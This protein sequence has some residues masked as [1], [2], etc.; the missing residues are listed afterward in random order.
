MRSIIHTVNVDVDLKMSELYKV[1]SLVRAYK[2][3]PL[4]RTPFPTVI[5]CFT[6]ESNS[7]RGLLGNR[8]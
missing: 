8:L 4:G 7:V 6:H 2:F 5:L 1:F 3:R